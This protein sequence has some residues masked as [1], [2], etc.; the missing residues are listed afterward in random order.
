MEKQLKSLFDFQKFSPNQKL[1]SIIDDVES[2]YEVTKL[3]DDD[4]EYASA[5]GVLDVA[6]IKNSASG[7]VDNN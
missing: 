5:A 7:P 3:D 4:L 2:R 1:Q 6:G